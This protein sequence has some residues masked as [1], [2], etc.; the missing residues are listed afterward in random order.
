M[1]VILLQDIKNVGKKDEIINANDGYARN[2]LFP[3]NLAIEATKD[4]L[5]KLQAKKDSKAHKK[6][7]E[8]QEFKKQAETINKLTLELKVKAGENGKIFGG[9]TSKEISEE[10]NKQYKIQVDKKKIVLKETIKNIGRFTVD[11]K[12]GEGINAKLTLNVMS[13]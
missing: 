6:S 11:I 12:F 3:K 8:I 5:L 2:F 10:L 7:L 1:K 13:E 9:V 4:N